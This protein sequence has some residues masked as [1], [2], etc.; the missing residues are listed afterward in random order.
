MSSRMNDNNRLT[1]RW[2]V[3]SSHETDEFCYVKFDNWFQ[4]LGKH[5][6]IHFHPIR[7]TSPSTLIRSFNF[8]SLRGEKPFK[9]SSIHPFTSYKSS[10]PDFFQKNPR[11]YC[12]NMQ[13]HLRFFISFVS[14][15]KR[16]FGWFV[17]CRQRNRRKPRSLLLPLPGWLRSWISIILFNS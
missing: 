5:E 6:K 11:S 14:I 9:S 7:L 1:P 16:P 8:I 17:G 10:E 2:K 4:K 13:F 3:A 12:S 15:I